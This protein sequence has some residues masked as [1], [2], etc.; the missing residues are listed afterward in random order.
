MH[1]NMTEVY[2]NE[3][4]KSRPVD[5]NYRHH[6]ET[7]KQWFS[8]F[9]SRLRATYPDLMNGVR[10]QVVGSVAKGLASFRSD[11]DI[12]IK[13]KSSDSLPVTRVKCA[14]FSLLKEM[15]ETGDQTYPVDVHDVD[16]QLRF[17]A[18]AK[19]RRQK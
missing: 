5:I 7:R 15:K 4:G 11:I 13:S 19:F 9:E 12:I 3:A 10:I 17:S 14:I 18:I 16:N 1:E 8:N 2:T 6:S